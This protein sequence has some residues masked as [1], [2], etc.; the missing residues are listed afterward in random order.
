VIETSVPR[1]A[2]V[3]DQ[4]NAAT[5][6]VTYG[7]ASMRSTLRSVPKVARNS[8]VTIRTGMAVYRISSG[9]CSRNLAGS[10][11]RPSR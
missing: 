6:T 2:N 5:S 3:H 10:P 1:Y 11:A 7:S 8:P 4:S 9:T